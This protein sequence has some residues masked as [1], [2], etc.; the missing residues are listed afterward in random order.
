M[1]DNIVAFIIFLIGLGMIAYGASGASES[2]CPEA[3][4]KEAAEF[5][6]SCVK[7]TEYSAGC[8]AFVEENYCQ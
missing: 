4:R 8:Y 6:L 2:K 7:E 5:L 3:E 1:K